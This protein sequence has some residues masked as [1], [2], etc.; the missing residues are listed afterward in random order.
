MREI[1]K[2]GKQTQNVKYKQNRYYGNTQNTIFKN[3]KKPQCLLPNT[4]A[5]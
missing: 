5:F 4:E 3:T 2:Q 1:P